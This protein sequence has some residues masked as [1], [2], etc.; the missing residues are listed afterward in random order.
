MIIQWSLSGVYKGVEF[1]LLFFPS[2][3]LS[4]ATCTPSSPPFPSRSGK[5]CISTTQ[6][7]MGFACPFVNGRIFISFTSLIGIKAS[8]LVSFSMVASFASS[9]SRDDL[10]ACELQQ[11]L[12]SSCKKPGN[13]LWDKR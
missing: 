4:W 5:T 1:K 13:W 8:I 7:L 9:S 10:D 2:L 11:Q 6:H 3:F 12:F